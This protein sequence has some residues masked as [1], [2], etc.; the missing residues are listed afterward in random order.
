[1][2]LSR[3]LSS[4]SS[5]ASLFPALNLESTYLA[6]QKKYSDG[7]NYKDSVLKVIPSDFFI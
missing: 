1:M 3:I 2:I 6:A 4:S 5:V 7:Y